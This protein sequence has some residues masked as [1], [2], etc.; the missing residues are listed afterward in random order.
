LSRLELERSPAE[1][2]D[3]AGVGEQCYSRALG[4]FTLWVQC[5][6][7]GAL[8]G[9]MLMD[10]DDAIAFGDGVTRADAERQLADSVAELCPELLPPP[11]S[12]P[13]LFDA[14]GRPFG[15]E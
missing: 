8:W 5:E 1:G 13:L 4:K 15:G 2:R 12:R 7:P 6:Y 9:W 10:G 11:P 3:A 14:S